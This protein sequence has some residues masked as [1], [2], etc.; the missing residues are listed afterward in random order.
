MRT[1]IIGLMASVLAGVGRTEEPPAPLSPPTPVVT[2]VEFKHGLDA[3]C[4]PLSRVWFNGDYLRWRI[5][6]GPQPLPLVTTRGVAPADFTEPDTSVVYGRSP[7]D[8]PTLSGYR[9]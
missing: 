2:P 8:Y 1:G 6:D 4:P 7:F 3:C 9:L 5:K